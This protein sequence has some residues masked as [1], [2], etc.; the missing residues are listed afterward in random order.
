MAER[1]GVYL[2]GLFIIA[3]FSYLFKENRLYRYTEHIYVG[4]G[5]AHA[6]VMG[7]QN[8]KETA[9][10]PLRQGEIIWIVPLLL[11]CLLY[12]RFSRSY[13]YLSRTS[14]AFMMGVAAGVTIIGA[15]DAQLIRQ[16]R[17]TMLPLTNLNNILLVLGT[18]STLAFFLFIPLGSQ[19]NK[20]SQNAGTGSGSTGAKQGS[21]LPAIMQVLS[22][23]GRAT[24][25]VAF[26]SAYG[27]VVMARLSYLIARLQFLFGKVVPLLPE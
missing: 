1:I 3:C 17:A 12:T 15:I 8:I 6:I 26:G 13:S 9:I 24:M 11:G 27:Y 25:M 16:V 22:T 20:A 2:S 23:M 4:F 10:A 7:W 5:A 18:V 19:K 21:Q 14:V